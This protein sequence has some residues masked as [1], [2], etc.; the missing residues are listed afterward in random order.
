MGLGCLGIR[1]RAGVEGQF[2]I[3]SFNSE[4]EWNKTKQ[5]DYSSLDLD[6]ICLVYS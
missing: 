1:G 3:K 2:D 6:V 5:I 4:A